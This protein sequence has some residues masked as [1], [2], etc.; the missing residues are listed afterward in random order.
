MTGPG[1]SS[2]NAN[3]TLGFSLAS[4]PSVTDEQLETLGDDDLCLLINKFQHVYHNRQRRKNPR[5]Y[6]FS[7]PNRFIADYPKKSSGGQNNNLDYYRHCDRDEGGS[8]K[9]RRRHKHRSRDRGGRFDKESLKKRFQ[10]KAKKRKKAFL[11]QL[12]DLDKSSDTDRSSSP[13]SDDD[14]KKKKKRDKDATGFIGLCLA[15]GRRKGFC[16]MAG[17]AN[18]ARASSGA[19]YTDTRRL[20]S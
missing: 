2:S 3:S 8:N 9:E 5:C 18:G 14:D 20:F 6:H 7:D 4:L 10:Y 11:A 17:E 19:C 12:S 13:T 1:G 16:T 15:A